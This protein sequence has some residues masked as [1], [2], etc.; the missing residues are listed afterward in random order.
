MSIFTINTC[1]FGLPIRVLIYILGII[2]Q[3]SFSMEKLLT[4]KSLKTGVTT[5][6]HSNQGDVEG[7]RGCL[8]LLL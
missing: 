7:R 4:Q 8:Q 5:E 2:R 6:F 1:S 3:H